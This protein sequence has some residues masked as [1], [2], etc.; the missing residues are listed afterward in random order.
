METLWKD[1]YFASR[2]LSRR[3][4]FTT[5]TVLIL[6]LGIGATASVL[7]VVFAVLLTALPYPEPEQIVRLQG[8]KST[9]GTQETWPT[10]YLDAVDWEEGSREWLDDFAVHSAPVAFNLDTE[11]QPERVDGEIV[12]AAYFRLL[13]AKPISGRTFTLDEEKAP[14]AP[15]AVILTHGLWQ[16]VFGNDHEVLGTSLMVNE[17]PYEIVG[18]MPPGFR[19]ISDKADLWLPLM[20]SEEL[21]GIPKIFERRGIRWLE[22]E[23]RLRP[24]VMQVEAQGGLDGLSAELAGSYPD[25]NQDMRSEVRGLFEHLYGPLRFPLFVLLGSALFVLILASSVVATLLLARGASRQHEIAVRSAQG[26]QRGQ[27]LRQLLT[28][29]LLLAMIGAAVGLLLAGL[30]TRGLVAASAVEFQSWVDIHVDLR[31][32]GATLVLT[33]FAGALAGLAPAWM[34][35]RG[36][37]AMVLREGNGLAGRSHQRIHRLLVGAEVAL[38]IV[39]LI[40]ASLMIKGFIKE[41]SQPLGLMADNLLTVRVDAKGPRYTEDSAMVLLVREYLDALSGLPGVDQVAVSAPDIPSD[42]W[43]GI[44]HIVED[45]MDETTGGVRFMVFKMVSPGFFSMLNIPLIDG[46]DFTSADTANNE[47]VA[48]IDARGAQQLWPDENPIG[49]RVR[50]GRRDPTAPWRTIIGV[51]GNVE[52]ERMQELEWPGPDIYY[53]ILQF[54]PALEPRFNFLIHAE[55]ID[56]LALSGPV[57]ER[58]MAV[59]PQLP[60]Y[61]VNTLESRIAAYFARDRFLVSLMS[62]FA[63]VAVILALMGLS[64]LA[65]YAVSQG[66]R[67]IGLRM[68]LGGERRS[69]IGLILRRIMLVV[70]IGIGVGLTAAFGL[71]RVFANLF[72]GLN[73]VDMQVYLVTILSIGAAA[74]LATLLSTRKILAVEPTVILRGE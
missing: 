27:L 11:G 20:M 70:V 8:V 37:P 33:C 6:A 63:G 12:N 17:Q 45:H 9:N 30:M 18:V 44:S 74:L 64:A 22:V 60:P 25:T 52:H 55:T 72:F 24:G 54:P 4:G 69:I 29:S 56:P 15:R 38:A 65:S 73:P 31:V 2:R 46:R 59:A 50:F 71:S 7:S 35:I 34:S 66:Q 51:V 16:R 1:L 10:S 14:G 47:L 40:G 49:K 42:A 39:L 67:E 28:E 3:P 23:A 48:I 53:P 13:G 36:N 21:L 32:L 19:G 26:A 58:M 41:R 61:D 57:Q 68:A 62:A 43:F 5:V